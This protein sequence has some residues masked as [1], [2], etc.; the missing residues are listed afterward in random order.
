MTCR[1]G[2][3]SH[4]RTLS[5]NCSLH[6]PRRKKNDYIQQYSVYKQGFNSLSKSKLLYDNVFSTIEKATKLCYYSTKLLQFHLQRACENDD[7]TMPD[8]T[9]TTDS[10]LHINI[11]IIN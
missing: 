9:D 11:M 7:I 2:S 8:I 4:S 6:R 3:N 10:Y 1:C 5:K